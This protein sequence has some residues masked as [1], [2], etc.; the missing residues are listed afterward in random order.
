MN[1]IPIHQ[2]DELKNHLSFSEEMLDILV[3]VLSKGEI[4]IYDETIYQVVHNNEDIFV[5]YYYYVDSMWHVSSNIIDSFYPN[6]NYTEIMKNIYKFD[7]KRNKW[8]WGF[9]EIENHFSEQELKSWVDQCVE[10]INH[11]NI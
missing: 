5:N 2:F 9:I 10:K 11:S 3:H 7:D 1:I 8:D 4:M 6:D